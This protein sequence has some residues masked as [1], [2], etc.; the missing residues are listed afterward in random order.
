MARPDVNWGT[1][2]TGWLEKK[3]QNIEFSPLVDMIEF[4]SVQAKS[5]IAKIRSKKSS[6]SVADMFD[7][8]MS[9]N[10]L[11]QFTEM[12]TSVVSAI[13]TSISTI[14]RNLGK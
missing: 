7:L 14:N 1:I 13:N 8:Q 9:M 12:S 2:T 5:Q 3:V 10:K 6:M 4:L 11:S